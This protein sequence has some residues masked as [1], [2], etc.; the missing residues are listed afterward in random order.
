MKVPTHAWL[1]GSRCRGRATP[2]KCG[3][4]G[5]NERPTRFGLDGHR[6]ESA[7]LPVARYV[8]HSYGLTTPHPWDTG[9]EAA[10]TR[11][12]P[13]RAAPQIPREASRFRRQ[14]SVALAARRRPAPPDDRSLRPPFT[15]LHPDHEDHMH[16]HT[17]KCICARTRTNA[18][19]R[20]A[21]VTLFMPLRSASIH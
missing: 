14:D 17:H 3:G 10:P 6:Y 9:E 15:G 5:T 2:K 12:R 18:Q 1:R 13:A 20:D 19:A 7:E 16:T 8:P 21:S 11:P 4:R